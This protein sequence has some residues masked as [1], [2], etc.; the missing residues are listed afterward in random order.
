[1]S[2]RST[3]DPIAEANVYVAYGRYEQAAELLEK[4]IE[5]EP[6]RTDLRDLLVQ[7]RAKGPGWSLSRSNWKDW[8]A[9]ALGSIGAA[10]AFSS[11]PWSLTSIVGWAILFLS[12]AFYLGCALHARRSKVFR[13]RS[14]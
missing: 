10:L 11:E 8:V 7:V 2:S 14:T 12:A 9:S 4:A 13:D 6:S 1:M 5:K 3:P